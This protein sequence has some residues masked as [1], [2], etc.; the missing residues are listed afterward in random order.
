MQVPRFSPRISLIEMAPRPAPHSGCPGRPALPLP[1][2]SPAPQGTGSDWKNL[3]GTAQFLS[4]QTEPVPPSARAGPPP[5]GHSPPVLAP[6]P[7]GRPSGP[8]PG[9]SP[10]VPPPP[11][12]PCWPPSPVLHRA[13]PSPT[14]KNTPKGTGS[15]WKKFPGTAH[16]DRQTDRHCNFN[17]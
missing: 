8:P 4:T 11:P 9:P 3:P 10:P 5:P 16:T 14:L 15:D 7:P 6:S 13:L 17:I 12:R 1:C 2:L